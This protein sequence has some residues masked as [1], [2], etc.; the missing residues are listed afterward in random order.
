MKITNC[1]HECTNDCRGECCDFC[2]WGESAKL[3]KTLAS[4]KI[5]DSITVAELTKA[6][7]NDDLEESTSIRDIEEA[8]DE[9]EEIDDSE[10]TRIFFTEGNHLL[11]G[12]GR[13]SNSQSMTLIAR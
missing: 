11:I 8:L 3:F 10:V 6:D 5:G 7:T 1:K 4:L 13:I 9:F 12:F 2:R